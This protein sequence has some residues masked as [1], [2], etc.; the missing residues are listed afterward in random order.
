MSEVHEEWPAQ[1]NPPE[2][3]FVRVPCEKDNEPA[4]SNKSVKFEL[5][6]SRRPVHGGSS[7]CFLLASSVSASY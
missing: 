3:S 5:R 7:E 2:W 4:V 1:E 6:D